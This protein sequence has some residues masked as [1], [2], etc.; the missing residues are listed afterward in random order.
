[1]NPPEP[2]GPLGADGRAAGGPR[3]DLPR[4]PHRAR[5]SGSRGGVGPARPG[6][7]R[8][9]NASEGTRRPSEEEVYEEDAESAPNQGP[10]VEIPRQEA[11]RP[12]ARRP[13]H[14]QALRRERSSPWR[15]SDAVVELR[16]LGV[17]RVFTDG[18]NLYTE[19]L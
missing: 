8:A 19:N 18:R 15:E 9:E 5:T 1:E 14:A 7:R 13:P 10:F 17:S 11:E 4:R 6:T 12:P 3:G 16:P 2:G